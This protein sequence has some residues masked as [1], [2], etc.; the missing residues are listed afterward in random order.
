[1]RA[2]SYINYLLELVL[3]LLA[4][5]VIAWR[6]SCLHTLG[7]LGGIWQGKQLLLQL[8]GDIDTG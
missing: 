8:G 5:V 7:V 1:M 6:V 2:T 4:L 3:A